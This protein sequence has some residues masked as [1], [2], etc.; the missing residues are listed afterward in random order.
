MNSQLVVEAMSGAD[1]LETTRELARQ[2]CVVEAELLVHLGEID[3]RQL[4]LELA[5]G[6][7]HVFCVKELGFSEDAAYYRIRVARAARRLPA[8]IDA[9]RSGKVHLAG[10][11]LL[12][13]HLTDENHVELL[14][15]ASGKSKRQIEEIVARIAPCARGPTSAIHAL[16]QDTFKIEFTATRG[17]R[18]KL[19][20]AQGLLRHRVPDGDIARILEVA[21]DLL[22][23]NVRKERFATGRKPR[24]IAVKA[25]ATSS[26][27]IPNS[28]KRA[29]YERDGRQCTF[30]DDRGQ[31]CPETGGLEFDHIDG[32]AITGVHD[33]DRIRLLCRAHNKHEAALMYG[34][35]FMER[36][37]RSQARRA[38][39]RADGRADEE[40]EAPG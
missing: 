22:I 19:V 30:M 8:I 6:S 29:V 25:I 12:V 36:A 31:R 28:I 1:L 17:F 7:M 37:R 32:F 21:L 20:E 40:D 34:H 39:G 5:H 18:E 16:S 11:R 23:E 15:E 27:H 14:A 2:A 26:R 13:P 33:I 9:I 35:A 38:P 4:Y 10:A 3:E 24:A